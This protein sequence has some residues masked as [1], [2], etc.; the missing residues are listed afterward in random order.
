MIGETISHYRVLEKLG[1]GGMGVVYKAED[2]RLHRFVALKFLPDEVAHDPQSLERFRREARAAS[3]LSHPNICTIFEIDEV[4]GRAFIAME[5]LEG[6]TLATM[7]AGKPL[8]L[9]TVLD[10]GIQIASALDAAHAKGIVHRDIKAA[11]IFVTPGGHVK[12]LDFG[13]AKIVPAKSFDA[14]SKQATATLE[15]HLTSPGAAMGTVAY[16]SPEQVRGKELDARTDLF[17]FGAVLYEMSTGIRPFLGDTSGVIFDGILN[18]TPVEPVRLNPSI[19]RKLEEIISKALEKDRE[20]RCQ[21]AAEL[22]ADLKRLRRDIESGRSGTHQM[23]VPPV[24]SSAPH[25]SRRKWPLAVGSILALALAAFVG[26]WLALRHA[27]TTRSAPQL[28]FAYRLTTNPTDNAISGSAISPDGKYLAYSDNT[29]TYLRLLSTGEIHPLLPKIT[30]AE[31]FSWF[32]DSTE[33]LASWETPSHQF[34]LWA[35]SILGGTPRQLSEEGW[36]A[37]VSPDGS[38]I[39]FLK[40]ARFG[41]NGGEIWVMDANGANQRKVISISPQQEVFHSPGWSPDDRRIVYGVYRPYGD[42]G[43]INSCAADGSD[44]KVLLSDT[45]L[46]YGL[47]WLADGRLLFTRREP[48]S[49]EINPNFATSNPN[50]T[51]NTNLWFVQMENGTVRMTPTRVTNGYG[52]VDQPSVTSDGKH[53]VF[54]RAKPEADVYVAE[55]F[56]G[57]LQISTPRRL[58]LDDADDYPFDWTADSK[59]VL[60]SSNRTGTSNIFTQRID[61]VSADVL[62]SGSGEKSVSRMS[63]DGRHVFYLAL[64][65]SGD[66]AAMVRMMRAPVNGGPPQRVLELPYLTNYQCSRAPATVCLLAQTEPNQFLV[67]RFDPE[68]GTTQPF[69]KLEASPVWN[70]SLSPDGKMVA[71]VKYST[72]QSTVQLLPVSGG[73]RREIIVKEWSA[74]SSIDWSAD[75]RGFFISSNPTG[76]LP[77]LL[78]LDLDGNAHPLWSMKRLFWESWAIPSRDGKHLAISAPTVESN[79]WKVDNF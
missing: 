55:F 1:G 74:I 33:L 29:G 48:T 9:E 32:P 43:S 24:T 6:Q 39:V 59:A 4:D 20:T 25:A 15:E 14:D 61:Q 56:S 26:A 72:G 28:A 11:N 62:V 60:F 78:Y 73:P 57:K 79:V 21:T 18:R 23:S 44:V 3:A 30:S 42:E 27:A 64:S 50:N 35:F 17:S 51:N 37:S 70:W 38:K 75:S 19:P 22:R 34:G 65:P 67:L 46:R 58:T 49:S 54:S 71:A 2:T 10:L 77:T 8:E 41:E 53:L 36:A 68:T 63:P 5:L 76:H 52:F 66:L 16:M 45:S 40:S 13:L 69:A 47:K 12:I 31:H 7:I